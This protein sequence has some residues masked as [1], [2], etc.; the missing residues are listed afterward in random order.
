MLVAGQHLFGTIDAQA[1]YK[2]MRGLAEG[3][4][5]HAVIV[6][7]R[8]AGLPGRIFEAEPLVDVPG[9]KLARP[10]EAGERVFVYERTQARERTQQDEIGGL[11]HV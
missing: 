7:R 1:G 5:K 11:L 4:D 6:E 10:V 3:T 9:E 8:Q 2:V